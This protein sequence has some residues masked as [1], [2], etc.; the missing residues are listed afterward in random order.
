MKV[1][2]RKL[3]SLLLFLA[4]AASTLTQAGGT[5]VQTPYQPGK[6]VFEFYFDDPNKIGSALYWLRS[7]MNT[8]MDA[9]Y[10]YDPEELDIKVVLHGTEIVTLVKKNEEKY[11]EAVGRMRYYSELGVEFKVCGLAAD[12][13][14][15]KIE[16]FQDFVQLIPNAQTELA[17]WQQQGY[18]LIKPEIMIKVNSTESIR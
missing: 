18:A 17:Y 7:Y 11:R 15:Y 12:E 2:L 5:W 4:I 13:F 16:D 8:L 10:S 14:G 3:K 9:P 6:V 1:H